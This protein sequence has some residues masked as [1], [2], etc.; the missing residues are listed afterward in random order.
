MTTSLPL[1]IFQIG[2]TPVTWKS[3]KQS[4]VALSTAEAEYMALSSAAQ[5]AIW[6]ML[7]CRIVSL[8]LP[9]LLYLWR[10]IHSCT[11]GRN[12]S[13]SSKSA[14][15]RFVSSTVQLRT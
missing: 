14:M 10:K 6:I 9:C 1:D 13:T 15:T 11:K 4:C 12:T 5:E 8:N 3:K 2:G 7:I